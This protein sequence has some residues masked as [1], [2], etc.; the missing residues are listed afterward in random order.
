[1][2]IDFTNQQT[3]RI[4]LEKIFNTDYIELIKSFSVL[5]D[6]SDTSSF[7]SDKHRQLVN[8]SKIYLFHVTTVPEI[9]LKTRG[10][11]NLK[12]IL[13]SDNYLNNFL[14]TNNIIFNIKNKSVDINGC[15]YPLDNNESISKWFRIEDRIYNDNNINGFYYINPNDADYSCVAKV[16]EFIYDLSHTLGNNNLAKLWEE[17]HSHFGKYIK[18]LIPVDK[19][20]THDDME[21]IVS[22]IIKTLWDCSQISENNWRTTDSDIIYLYRG[23]SI[24]ADNIIAINSVTSNFII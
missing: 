1:M 12:D 3:C 24:S 13:S 18:A 16:P 2:I 20:D 10:L 9:E 14:K 23:E 17:K 19:I 7:I 6:S 21:D 5:E 11:L 22:I 4:T 15:T 8:N